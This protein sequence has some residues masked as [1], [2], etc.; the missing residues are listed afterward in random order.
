[1][2]LTAAEQRELDEL[3]YRELQAKQAASLDPPFSGKGPLDKAADLGMRALDYTSGPLRTAVGTVAG[4]AT[5]QDWKDTL[6]GQ[7][8]GLDTYAERAGIPQGPGLSEA[9]SGIPKDSFLDMHP[10]GVV[11]GL[12]DMLLSPQTVL[13]RLKGLTKPFKK[14]P[15][16][17]EFRKLQENPPK[18]PGKI[19]GAVKSIAMGNPLG[20]L[21]E[22]TGN[23]YYKSAFS[24]A[25]FPA[26]ASGKIPLS[27]VGMENN[28]WGT[29]SSMPKAFGEVQ[30]TLGKKLN[31]IE[32]T[33]SRGG[34]GASVPERLGDLYEKA[35][36]MA[37]EADV[38]PERAAGKR[39]AKDIARMSQRAPV[40]GFSGW[41]KAK[42]SNQKLA[43]KQ[44]QYGGN[45]RASFEGPLRSELANT[46]MGVTEDL[47]DQVKPGLGGKL[48]QTNARW[49]AIENAMPTL[50]KK[51]VSSMMETYLPR[52]SD[53][54][55]GVAAA[56]SR[57]TDGGPETLATIL[58][59]AYLSKGLRSNLGRTGLGL[60]LKKIGA[61]HTLDPALRQVG[62]QALTP[63]DQYL[64]DM[65]KPGEE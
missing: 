39:V 64:A 9:V 11:A 61:S 7:A 58:G 53:L 21:V 48:Q 56:L 23:K 33:A 29:A 19:A 4:Q 47:A 31:A 27:Q 41:M 46:A 26:T 52:F 25:D 24:K 1:M 6:K 40:R 17:E 34:A 49:G 57:G 8:P 13:N 5:M 65:L 45:A 36:M 2:A 59:A 51:A 28:I 42:R 37:Q 60:G 16:A 10:R 14:L 63:E 20:D 44:G 32:E 55:I 30:E 43:A 54:P 12:G 18:G 62:R 15:T 38:G 22:G 3:E 35:K 50:N